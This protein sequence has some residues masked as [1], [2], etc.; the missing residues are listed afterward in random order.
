MNT[1]SKVGQ[2]Y[3]GAEDKWTEIREKM[4]EDVKETLVEENSEM[5][6]ACSPVVRELLVKEMSDQCGA[7]ITNYRLKM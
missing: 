7:L 1:I 2:P 5:W 4:E 3:E 6:L